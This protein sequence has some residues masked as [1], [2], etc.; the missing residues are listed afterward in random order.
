MTQVPYTLPLR[1]HMI[2]STVNSPHKIHN[3]IGELHNL[4]ILGNQH[5]GIQGVHM[6]SKENLVNNHKM[7]AQQKYF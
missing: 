5:P 6:L 4:L 2:S 3:G 7:D 1:F